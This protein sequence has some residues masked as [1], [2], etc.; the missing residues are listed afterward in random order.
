[1]GKQWTPTLEDALG[2]HP[3]P[4]LEPGTLLTESLTFERG[5]KRRCPRCQPLGKR[6]SPSPPAHRPLISTLCF[7]SA[8]ANRKTKP[9][10]DVHMTFS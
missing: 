3:S 8:P 4:Y 7:Y 10:P 5:T 9:R 6:R 1:M 2:A